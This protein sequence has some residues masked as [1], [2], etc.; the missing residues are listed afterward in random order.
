MSEPRHHR[1]FRPWRNCDAP[2]EP[3]PESDL[4]FPWRANTEI[5]LGPTPRPGAWL[6]PTPERP[7]CSEAAS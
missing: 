6:K 5:V 4:V 3:L 7:A 1:D 2:L